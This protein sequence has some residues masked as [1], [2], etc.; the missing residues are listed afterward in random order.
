LETKFDNASSSEK[1]LTLGI[2][3]PLTF[4]RDMSPGYVQLRGTDEFNFS[5]QTRVD[6]SHN[7]LNN[8]SGLAVPFQHSLEREYFNRG[9]YG[10]DYFY[11]HTIRLRNA[12]LRWLD[13]Q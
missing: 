1:F 7:N 5:I 3:F 13:E 11:N 4:W 2:S 8:G 10:S 12:Y 9:R 6:D